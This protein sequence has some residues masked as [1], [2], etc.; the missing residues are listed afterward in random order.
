MILFLDLVSQLIAA[1]LCAAVGFIIWDIGTRSP[2][3]VVSDVFCA[4]HDPR[5]MIGGLARFSAGLVFVLIS[6]GLIFFAIPSIEAPRYT[7]Y[8]IG[9]FIIALLIEVLVGDDVRP[10]LGFRRRVK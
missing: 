4:A 7:L 3:Q 2:A 5:R 8:Q 1:I 9:T 6:I 10:L